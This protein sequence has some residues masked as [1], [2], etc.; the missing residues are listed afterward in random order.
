MTGEN[1]LTPA[2]LSPLRIGLG[3]LELDDW[4]APRPGD[5]TLLAQRRGL[6]A[7]KPKEVLASLPEGEAPVAE[8]AAFLRGRGLA[9]REGETLSMLAALAGAVAEDLL[10]LA[11]A[12]DEKSGET[13][14]LVAGVLC[15]PNRWRLADKIGKGLTAIHA[16]VPE[17]A[18]AL[19]GPVDRFLARLRP[20]RAFTRGNWG[21]ASTADLHLPFPVAPVDPA[22]DTGFFLRREE[23]GFVKLPA[24]EA[25]V[26]SIRTTVT[27]WAEVPAA[28]RDAIRAVSGLLSPE[29]RDYKSL[30]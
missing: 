15:F 18:A 9:V 10:L 7:G 29:W 28:Q 19:A 8:L 1:I 22:R 17:Y 4:L 26:F 21:L 12:L 14:R 2:E 27:P 3:P 6:V 11:P 25:V 16:P 24:T 30:K 13:T 23:Q 5:E 20:G